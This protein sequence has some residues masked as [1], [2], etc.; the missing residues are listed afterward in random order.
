MGWI[1][2]AGFVFFMVYQGVIEKKAK[3]EIE[4]K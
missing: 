2:L 4:G 1:A 3:K